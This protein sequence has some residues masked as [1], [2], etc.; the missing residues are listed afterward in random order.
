MTE[1]TRVPIQPIARGSLIKLW[2][3]VILA[4]VIGA[5]IAWAVIPQQVRV[6]ELSPGTGGSPSA[7]DVVLVNYVGKL[8]DGSVFDSG[9]RAPL[10]L[11]AMIPGFAEGLTQMEKGGKYR[12]EIPA[13]EGYGAEEKADPATGKIVIPANS[14]LVFEVELIDFISGADFRQ[15]QQ[16]QQQMIQAEAAG[17]PGAGA[18]SE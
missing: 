16:M 14:D 7:D 11:E 17:E 4:I 3:G 2:L 8:E 9:E 10:P 12:L 5:G 15:M 13:D 18:P 1:I 6:T